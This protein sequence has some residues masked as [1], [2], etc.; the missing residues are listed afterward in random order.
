MQLVNPLF[1]FLFLPLSLL[2]LLVSGKRHRKGLLTALSLLWLLFVNRSTPAALLPIVLLVAALCLLSLL[3]D[4][5]PRVRLVFSV[6]LP[7]VTLL[8]ARLLAEYASFRYPTGLTMISL[9]AVSMAIDRYRGDAPEREGP[10]AV[11]SYLLFF[12]TMLVGPLLR[13]KQFLY[14]TE[15]AAPL[16]RETLARGACLFMRGY[17][18]RVALAAVLMRTFADVRS[19]GEASLPPLALLLL[20]LMAYAFLYAFVTGTTDMARGVMALYGIAPPRAQSG[21]VA[22]LMPHR[23]LSCMLLPLDRY[24]EDYLARPVRAR[25][26]G[27]RGRMLAATLTVAVTVLFY[28]TRPEML[29]TAL[30][31]FLT[32][33]L[34]VK[35]PRWRRFPHRIPARLFLGT[36]SVL[37]LSLLAL[38]MM[39]GN[40]LDVVR[41]IARSFD[42]SATYSVYYLFGAIADAGYLT[43]ALAL[44]AF[45]P[46]LHY[47]PMLASRLPRST[48]TA[49][50]AISVIL[51][52]LAFIGTVSYF[53]PQ[54]PTDA[55]PVYG[56][57]FFAR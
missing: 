34:S 21:A 26:H 54:F 45:S 28:R 22:L 25:V 13:Y 53:M 2:P 37:S 20:L 44:L 33:W 19:F 27:M 5:A 10:L 14:A 29:L 55:A 31:L 51:L 6:A 41:L 39:L 35:L 48:D 50:R 11:I 47:Y 3:P 40:P 30:P 43:P 8:A 9:A 42:G 12:P 24:I 36:L 7:L 23:V 15:H 16:A 49:L 4:R 38:S 17:V 57:S 56:T 1:M 32:A 52:I 46:V 18:K